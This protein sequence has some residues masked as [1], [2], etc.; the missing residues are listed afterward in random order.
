MVAL[1][2]VSDAAARAGRLH[3]AAGHLRHQRC[4]ARR[5][6]SRATSRWA[7]SSE[8]PR[9]RCEPLAGFA[10][11]Q[12]SSRWRPQ[13][14]PFSS[15]GHTYKEDTC[16]TGPRSLSTRSK[17]RL[18]GPAL[19]RESLD[20]VRGSRSRSRRGVGGGTGQHGDSVLKLEKKRDSKVN[21]YTPK[22]YIHRA[23]DKFHSLL[24]LLLF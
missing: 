6:G 7:T 12:G 5:R 4:D 10:Q 22:K 8:L 20:G 16:I 11:G 24:R 2:A 3:S 23:T 14:W 9:A 21:K 15:R 13:I 18:A 19:N 1:L 17:R